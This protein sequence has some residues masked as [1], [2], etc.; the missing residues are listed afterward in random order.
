MQKRFFFISLASLIL[1]SS[2]APN[3]NTNSVDFSTFPEV[4]VT[5]IARLGGSSADYAFGDWGIDIF[6]TPSNA[7]IAADFEYGIV[8][9]FSSQ[10][11]VLDTL[12]HK[13]DGPGEVSQL[14]SLHVYN[15]TLI[16]MDRA[17][18]KTMIVDVAT[19]KVVN[20][21]ALPNLGE[22]G[23]LTDYINTST[24]ELGI[25]SGNSFSTNPKDEPDTREY[26]IV[27]FSTN[28]ESPKVLGHFPSS[29]MLVERDG[30]SVSASFI[31]F[32][33]TTQFAFDLHRNRLLAANTG[34]LR[35]QQFS[36]NQATDS[37]VFQES[38]STIVEKDISPKS[39]T[40][41]DIVGQF[42]RWKEEWGDNYNEAWGQRMMAN[43]TF[44][45]VRPVL[46]SMQVVDKD[47][48]LLSYYETKD[49][50]RPYWKFDAEG[51]EIA[52]FSLPENWEIKAIKD[53]LL[54][55]SFRD[56]DGFE[57]IAIHRM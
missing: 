30:N 2:C 14:A 35:I 20:Q 1:A 29:R 4:N 3:E 21:A 48:I 7:L 28:G 43:M 52:R 36:L 53:T 47:N 31:P 38:V 10:G 23:F 27:A 17:R 33:T 51:N 34:S 40:R 8:T 9:L 57:V 15:S 41:A 26:K 11:D 18:Q 54:I 24:T 39:L 6:V 45:E 13:G 16:A 56:E 46:R 19:K 37:L 5:E 12:I 55:A 42:A 22:L 49:G 44:P 50:L 32:S 25:V